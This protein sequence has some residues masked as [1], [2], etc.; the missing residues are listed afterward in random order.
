VCVSVCVCVFVYVYGDSSIC[1]TKVKVLTLEA[2][3]L[4]DRVLCVFVCMWRLIHLC[5][6]GEG[7]DVGGDDVR[8]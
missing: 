6:Y 8:R 7:A 1:V 2:M 5:D 3:M 4:E